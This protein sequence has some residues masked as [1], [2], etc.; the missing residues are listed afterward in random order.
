MSDEDDS[1]SADGA[2]SLPA[3]QDE[4]V[5]HLGLPLSPRHRR[6]CQLIAAGAKGKQI[7][8]ELGYSHTRIS[9]LKRD[10]QIRAEV[11]RLQEKLFEEGIS[12]RLKDFAEP[13]LNNIQ[14]VLTDRSNRVKISE[15][16]EMSK[17]VIE[18]LDGKAIQ[19]HEI[20]ENTLSAVM[21][22]LDALKAA[23]QKSLIPEAVRPPESIEGEFT[24][25]S[26]P[27]QQNDPTNDGPAPKTEEDLVEEWFIGQSSGRK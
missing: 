22:R 10:P 12:R 15:K 3:R 18:K 2:E 21:D 16:A 11:T 9:K 8:A 25:I 20:G 17:W 14:A 24:E 7:L 23:G 26:V 6:L 27:E 1:D 13:A 5:I 19:K 4:E